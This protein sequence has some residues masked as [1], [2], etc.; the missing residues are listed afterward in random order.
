MSENPDFDE[1]RFADTIVRVLD[2]GEWFDIVPMTEGRIES[3]PNDVQ[4]IDV[5]E[6]FVTCHIISGCNPG[7]RERRS[8]NARRHLDLEA[9]LRGEGFDPQPALGLSPDGTWEEPSWSVAGMTRAQACAMGREFG[10]IAV[11][12]ID[13]ESMRVVRCQDATVSS[14]CR[15][16]MSST[17]S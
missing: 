15:W 6:Q 9:R 2:R 11:F 8:V 3:R 13:G 14:S 10:Q 17:S 7:Y 12:E 4:A 16:E 1:S 5:S